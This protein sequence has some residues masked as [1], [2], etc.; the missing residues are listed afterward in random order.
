MM[1]LAFASKGPVDD[2]LRANPWVVPVFVVL[3]VWLIMNFAAWLSGWSQ[4]ASR[5][6]ANG[7]FEGTKWR[8]QSA[9]TRYMTHYNNC[10]TFGANAQGL[11][12]SMLVL[13]R[14]GHPPI[15]APWSDITLEAKQ[16]WWMPGY[17][18]RFQQ[19]PGISM[20][21]RQELGDKIRRA[22]QETAGIRLAPQVG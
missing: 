5:Y 9:M 20:W 22:S 16:R 4:L 6:P 17:E 10:L 12:I 21:V 2:F 11:Y 18:L 19:C 7:P 3:W 14:P 15:L 1:M 13:F 8:F